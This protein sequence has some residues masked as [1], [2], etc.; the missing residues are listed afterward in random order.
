[1]NRIVVGCAS[2]LVVTGFAAAFGQDLYLAD[3]AHFPG[4]LWLSREGRPERVVHRRD[5]KPLAS[6]PGMIPR[7]AQVCVLPGG[8][9]FFCSGLDGYVFHNLNGHEVVSGDHKQQ[10]RD[11]APGDDDHTYYF[12]VVSTPQNGEPLAEG[13]IYRHDL[14][15]GGP[16]L[17]ATVKQ[18]IVGNDWWGTF[19]RK[20]EDFYVVTLRSPVRIYRLNGADAELKWESA[21]RRVT[22]LTFDGD[23]QPV[24][25]S[26]GTDIIRLRDFTD[27]QVLLRAERNMTE[28]AA[29]GRN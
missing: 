27:A 20:G 16:R 3:A 15:D 1:M 21:E 17:V 24:I 25:A 2:F 7:L 5:V 6:A 4:V 19:A 8:K 23:G 13:R 28:V 12:S 9:Q 18:E 10:V 22:A 26:G 11:L 14:Y 29:P